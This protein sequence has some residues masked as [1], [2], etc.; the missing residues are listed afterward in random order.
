MLPWK[1]SVP[2][3]RKSSITAV[4]FATLSTP[5]PVPLPELSAH[6]ERNT[7]SGRSAAS[8]RAQAVQLL[9]PSTLSFVEH[10][11]S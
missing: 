7:M 9:A 2:P 10:S 5:E 8:V 6:S 3:W 1:E 11:A 4:R